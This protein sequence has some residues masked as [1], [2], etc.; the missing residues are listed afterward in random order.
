VTRLRPLNAL[1]M[2]FCTMRIGCFFLAFLFLPVAN[3]GAVTFDL[4]AERLKNA[5]GSAMPSSGLV[6]LGA[7][8]LDSI[9]TAPTADQ[10]FSGDDF[11]LDRWDLTALGGGG[12]LGDGT[13]SGTTGPLTLSGN[14]TPGDSVQLY[15][16]PTLT[17]A[18]SSPG[19]G[20]PYGIYRHDTG[21]DGSEPWF[22]PA[23]GLGRTLLFLTDDATVPGSNPALAGNASLTVIPE[24]GHYA[25]AL[26]L[27]CMVYAVAS[28]RFR[29]P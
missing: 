1:D 18:S 27:A 23:D 14:W 13:F 24:P 3:F 2:I 21:L 10:F 12:G 4:G 29:K 25:M 19:A 6:I 22:T 7:S 5:D 16:F 17:L 20:T 9:F 11:E 28:R 26:G 15:W 8:T